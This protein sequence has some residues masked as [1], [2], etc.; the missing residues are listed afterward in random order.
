MGLLCG[1]VVYWKLVVQNV[2]VALLEI[3]DVIK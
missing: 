1:L 2:F 3:N